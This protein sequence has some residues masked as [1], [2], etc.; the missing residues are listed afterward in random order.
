M[1][2]S[3]LCTTLLRAN[4]ECLKDECWG[5]FKSLKEALPWSKWPHRLRPIRNK[6]SLIIE[7]VFP[8]MP[9]I[10]LHVLLIDA[11]FN[12]ALAALAV[13]MFASGKTFLQ[14]LDI[15]GVQLLWFLLHVFC[16]CMQ[17]IDYDSTIIGIIGQMNEFINK[18]C[19]SIRRCTTLWPKLPDTQPSS[20]TLLKVMFRLSKWCKSLICLQFPSLVS[21][22]KW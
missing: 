4:D 14:R 9:S 10:L 12:L 13:R 5:S 20:A 18:M 8:Y 21:K 22:V 19:R 7:N 15:V 2:Y 3:L 11:V 6:S 16:T 17:H 1:I